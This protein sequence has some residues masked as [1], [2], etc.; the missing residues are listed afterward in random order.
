MLIGVAIDMHD[1][2]PFLNPYIMS[3]NILKIILLACSICEL[4]LPSAQPH[5]GQYIKCA[6]MNGRLNMVLINMDLW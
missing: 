2:V 1:T 6:T 5:Q 3:S 4:M